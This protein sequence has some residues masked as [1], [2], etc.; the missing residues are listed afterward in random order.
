VELDTHGPRF[1]EAAAA[2]PA[3]GGVVVFGAPYDSTTSWRPGTRFGPA[4]ARLGSQVLETYSPAQRR[5]YADSAVCDLGDLALPLGAPGPAVDAIEAATREILSRGGAPLLLGGEHTVSVGAVRAVAAAHPDLVLVQ[6]DAHADLRPEYLGE[7]LN[8]ACAMRRCAEHLQP[9][10]LLQVGIRSGTREEFEEM[11]S[12]GAPIPPKAAALDAA[13]DALR[14]KPVYLTVDLDVFDPSVLPG[15]G[16]PEPGGIDWPT[17]EALL[18]TLE[19]ARLVGA[20]VVELSPH[21]DPSGRS[22]VVA[23]KVVRELILMLDRARR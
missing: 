10:H 12:R 6:L 14:G 19:G 15:T 7:P 5:D 17:F 2:L 3:G 13:L 18:R 8:H 4:H 20:D 21:W 16:T 1:L 22:S 9:G 23:A 11:A